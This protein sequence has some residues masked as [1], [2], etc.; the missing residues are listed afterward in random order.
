MRRRGPPWAW[1][2]PPQAGR[3]VDLDAV[4]AR[5]R[6]GHTGARKSG[7]IGFAVLRGGDVVGDHTVIFAGE[8]ERI[9]L[10]HRANDRQIYAV[11][12]VRAALWAHGQHP[13]PLLHAGCPG[14][15]LIY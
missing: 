7:D 5:I 6:D 1:A 14:A 2:A 9:E 8:G 10:S 4:S 15:G 12:A 13:G 3:G 11:G